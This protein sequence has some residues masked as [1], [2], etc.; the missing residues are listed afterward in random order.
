MRFLGKQRTPAAFDWT[1]YG[2]AWQEISGARGVGI[3]TP[4]Q[5]NETMEAFGHSKYGPARVSRDEALGDQAAPS[6]Y[7]KHGGHVRA[8]VMHETSLRERSEARRIV[9][10]TPMLKDAAVA[11]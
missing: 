10:Q 6:R 4:S 3:E 8:A 5:F 2:R 7:A 9:A 11:R 1:A